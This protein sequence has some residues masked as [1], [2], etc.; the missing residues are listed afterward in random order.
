MSNPNTNF[1]LTA[2]RRVMPPAD[3]WQMFLSTRSASTG[4]Y[5]WTRR[6]VVACNWRALPAPASAA[7]A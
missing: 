4:S 3:R 6:S 2:A 7:R 1:I 5:P